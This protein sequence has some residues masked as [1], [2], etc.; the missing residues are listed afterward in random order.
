MKLKLLVI[1]TFITFY[2]Y[3]QTPIENYESALDSNYS[4]VSGTI[5][6]TSSGS[7][8]WNFTVTPT[9]ATTQDSVESVAV[10][11][12]TEMAFPGTTSVLMTNASVDPPGESKVYIKNETNELS[13]TGLESS[14]LSLNYS[15]NGLL[16]TFPLETGNGGDNVS[17]TFSYGGESGAFSGT[18]TTVVDAYG[19]LSI[20]DVGTGAFSGEVTRLKIDQSVTL[21]VGGFPVGNM[22][23]T[24]FYYY[25]ATN[26]NLVFRY[27]K[28]DITSVVGNQ[29]SELKEVLLSS[30][31]NVSENKISKED[32]SLFPNPVQNNLNFKFNNDVIVKSI[33]LTDISGRVVHK[34]NLNSISVSQFQSGLYIATIRTNKG[35]LSRQFIKE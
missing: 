19:N 6:Q 31:L 28:F 7:T 23:Q 33:I 14:G 4:I 9:G 2:S 25:D 22:L 18:L 17:G 11:S 27:S 15:D 8:S 35:T 10:G 24:S 29:S 3:S 20:N 21:T 1:V 30:N 34:S 12:T 13:L 32:V 26:T 16:G 5:D